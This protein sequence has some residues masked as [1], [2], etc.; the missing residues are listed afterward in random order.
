MKV[1]S[2][3][4]IILAGST[5]NAFAPSA[6]KVAF[7]RIANSCP[8]NVCLHMNVPFFAQEQE[9][10][11]VAEVDETDLNSIS[12]E[13]EVEL[14]VQKEMGKTKRMSNLRNENGVEFAP[15]MGISEDEENKIR[16][17]SREKAAARRAR[18][19]QERDVSGN[20][21]RDSQAQE[22]SGTG[23]S[24]KII[25]GDVELEW[26]TKSESG[27]KGFNV[28]RRA[29]KTNE[30]T[31]IAS[32]KDWGPLVSKG[33]D[34]GIY[35]HLD[36]DVPIGGWVYRISEEDNFGNEADICQ[37]LIEVETE[38]EQRNAVIAGVGFGVVAVLA[39]VAG[40]ALDPLNGHL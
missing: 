15:W 20:L 33:S 24:Y 38:D 37:C 32:Y 28:K 16:Q 11:K 26:A 21:F 13:E 19:E 25:D 4:A 5:C 6:S 9:K 12:M 8:N 18:A 31:V 1:L 23:L 35:R 3:A 29:A 22:L 36:A 17:I 39:V 10:E 14:M 30:Y 40:I 2:S 7:S 27:T 34:G